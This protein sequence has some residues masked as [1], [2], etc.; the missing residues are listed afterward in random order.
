[1]VKCID[2]KGNNSKI[3]VVRGSKEIIKYK[4]KLTYYCWKVLKKRYG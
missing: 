1:M 2:W 4:K 3:K